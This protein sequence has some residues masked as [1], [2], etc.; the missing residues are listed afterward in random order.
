[1]KLIYGIL[2]VIAEAS[3]NMSRR[4]GNGVASN[5]GA[6]II[7]GFG[8]F[9]CIVRAIDDP[10]WWAWAG[11]IVCGAISGAFLLTSSLRHTVFQKV[12]GETLMPPRSDASLDPIPVRVIGVLHADEKQSRR[13]WNVPAVLRR[14][15][16]GEIG[17]EANLAQLTQLYGVTVSHSA[18]LWY[19]MPQRGSLTYQLGGLYVGFHAK[20][21]LKISFRDALRQNKQSSI[22]VAFENE[23]ARDLGISH[24]SIESVSR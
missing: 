16:N 1:M 12:S 10:V 5:V 24:L 21:A 8:C 6:I 15:S 4:R 19:W 9:L 11:A 23:A 7:C 22:V 2:G 3:G 20:P 18:K 14:L 17:I 13:W